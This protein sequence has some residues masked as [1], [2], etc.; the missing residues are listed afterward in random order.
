MQPVAPRLPPPHTCLPFPL[1][2]RRNY[3]LLM[4]TWKVAP[5]LAAGNCAVVKPSELASLTTLELAGIAEEVGL[6]PGVLNV[7]TGTGADAGA[8]L[9]WGG[10]GGG[11]GGKA[12]EGRLVVRQLVPARSS[13]CEAWP[14]PVAKAP[15][16]WL[17]LAPVCYAAPTP[18][19]PRS[20]SPGPLPPG[21]ACTPPA[22]PTCAPPPWVRSGAVLRARE[23][24]ELFLPHQQ[25][26]AK[27]VALT[28]SSNT[29]PLARFVCAWRRAGRQ[30]GAHR[31]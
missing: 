15:L 20:R 22:P 18:G 27:R 12:E 26:T 1:F 11:R 14:A 4:V 29:C 21:A 16:S 9:R 7:V 23:C 24:P 10:S 8:P 5:A 13:E 30:V 31:V 2:F 19:W 17:A 3:P 25:C 6:P 28:S